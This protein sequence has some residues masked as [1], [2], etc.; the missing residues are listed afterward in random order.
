[1]RKFWNEMGNQE[2]TIKALCIVIAVYW[3]SVFLFDYNDPFIPDDLLEIKDRMHN[4]KKLNDNLFLLIR[5]TL[6]LFVVLPSSLIGLIGIFFNKKWGLMLYAIV[7][8]ISYIPFVG[9]SLA[10]I[11]IDSG[12]YQYFRSL[13]HVLDGILIGMAWMWH[14]NKKHQT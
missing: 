5:D 12:Y 6:W 4:E 14:W 13:Y 9:T 3:V 2:K 8:C 7:D 1:M 10:D 11:D